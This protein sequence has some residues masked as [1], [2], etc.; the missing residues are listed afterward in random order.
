MALNWF[1]DAD[2]A[3]WMRP[4]F[5]RMNIGLGLFLPLL[6][7]SAASESPGFPGNAIRATVI[8]VISV[9]LIVAAWWLLLQNRNRSHL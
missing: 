3:W 2:I 4:W 8:L 1:T 9:A 6:W 5:D 7:A